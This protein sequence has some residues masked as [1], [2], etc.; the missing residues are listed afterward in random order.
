MVLRCCWQRFDKR[1]RE[2]NWRI[3]SLTGEYF[4]HKYGRAAVTYQWRDVNADNHSGVTKTNG[5]AVLDGVNQ[6]LGLQM[7]LL[8]SHVPG[9]K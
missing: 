1:D 5:H 8:F 9:E 2:T 4:F 7:T 6:R 3:W